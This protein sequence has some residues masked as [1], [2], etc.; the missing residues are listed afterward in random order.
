MS[1]PRYERVIF[2]KAPLALVLAQVRFPILPRFA[3]GGFVAP[4]LEALRSQYPRTERAQ[5][6]TIQLSPQGIQPGGPGGTLWRLATRD[7]R[8]TVVLAETAVTLEVRGYSAVDELL[9]RFETVLRTAQATLGVTEQVRLGLRY[10]NELRHP[11]AHSLADWVRLLRPEFVGFAASD[12]V[13]GQVAQTLQEVQWQ[14]ADGVLAVRHGFLPE[15]EKGSAPAIATGHYY[16]IDLDYYNTIE[17]ELRPDAVVT[18]LRA[19]NGVQYR[20]FRWTLGEALYEYL[21]PVHVS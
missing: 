13:E 17:T 21:E 5:Q 1:L 3:E 2:R 7:E 16:L 19:Y 20:F 10:V 18:Q 14:R 8:W 4:F 6:V 9:E 11:A 12:L 15:T